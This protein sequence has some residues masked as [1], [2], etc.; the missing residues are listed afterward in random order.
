MLVLSE[1]LFSF[2]SVFLLHEFLKEQSVGGQANYL[3]T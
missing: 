1:S 2:K 3:Q